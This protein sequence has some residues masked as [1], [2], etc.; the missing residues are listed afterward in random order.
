MK[1][2]LMIAILALSLAVP[3][4]ASAEGTGM[5]LAPKFIMSLQDSGTVSRSSGLAGS[6]VDE[7]DQFTLGGA[8][9]VGMDFWQ[10]QMIPLRLE[11]EVAFRGNS[12]TSWN[13]RGIYT[14]EVKALWNNT[15][16]FANVFWDFHNDSPF[17]PYIQG[18]LGLAFNYTG[19]E[20]T[21][22]N[23]ETYSCDD[24]FTNFAWNVGAGFSYDVNEVLSLDASYR[25][26]GLGYNELSKTIGGVKMEVGNEP[27]NN[28][29]MVGLRLKF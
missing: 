22:H 8:F 25:F 17:T 23:G 20:F 1:R 13:D 19:Y 2:F 18:G 21:M 14:N 29:F 16:L 4:L 11:V 5:Y 10:Q 15:T 28:E 7:Y 3:A 6:G 26:V 27:Y 12:E 9:A 24:R